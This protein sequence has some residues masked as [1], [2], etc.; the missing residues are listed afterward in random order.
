VLPTMSQL[1][2]LR[3][4]QERQRLED[5]FGDPRAASAEGKAAEAA[6][7]AAEG[8]AEPA[9]PEIAPKPAASAVAAKPTRPKRTKGK[10]A[11]A[12]VE[13]KSRKR[14]AAAEAGLEDD[15][16]GDVAMDANEFLTDEEFAAVYGTEERQR[17]EEEAEREQ[18]EADA[19]NEPAWKPGSRNSVCSGC[20]RN[21]RKHKGKAEENKSAS[22]KMSLD[23]D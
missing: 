16:A 11:Q 21:K 9:E 18:A 13:A 5:L 14:S 15:R 2:A 7:A 10:P 19:K 4:Q 6:P 22:S 8:E 20:G 3:E 1:A 23:G 12:A 17:E